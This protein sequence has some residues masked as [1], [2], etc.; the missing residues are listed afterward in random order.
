MQVG[1]TCLLPWDSDQPVN[2]MNFG[3]LTVSI[4]ATDQAGATDSE[5]TQTAAGRSCAPGR[6]CRL[7]VGPLARS[8]IGSAIG[9]SQAMR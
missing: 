4:V 6:G 1:P 9:E 8:A 2:P 7:C 5:S 3:W